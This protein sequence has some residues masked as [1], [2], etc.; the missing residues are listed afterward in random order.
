MTSKYARQFSL[1]EGFPQLLKDFTREVLRAQ[2]EDVYKFGFEYFTEA[3]KRRDN[4]DQYNDAS[5]KTRLSPE[6]LQERITALFTDADADGNGVLDRKE[7]KNVF[8][9][10]KE[11]LDL[12]QKDVM[13]I[14]AEA[15]ENDDGTIEYNEFVPIAVDVV[16]SIYAKQDFEAEQEGRK[17]EALEDARDFLLH[18]MPREELEAMLRD[19]FMKADRDGNGSLSRKEFATCIKEADLGFTRKEINVLLSE[20]DADND[21]KVTYEEFVPLCFTLLVEMVSESLVEAPQEEEELK[22]F[23]LQ[24]L[25]ASADAENKLHHTEIVN[26]LK[27]AD[28]GLTRVQIHAI[29]SEA[30]EDEQGRIDYEQLS[31]AMAGMVLCLVNV[32]MQQDRAEA[33]QGVRD[34]DGYGFVYGYDADGMYNALMGEFQKLDSGNQGVLPRDYVKESVTSAMPDISPKHC[35]AVMSLALPDDAGNVAY[36]DVAAEAY[37][38]LNWLAEQEQ[39]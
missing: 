38:V 28:L 2:T 11:E 12:D 37:A 31:N 25:G 24:L 19:V 18:G 26:L 4:P 10:L 21:G 17:E 27:D 36:G 5:A 33:L 9:G 20:V 32:Q 35:Q 34:S 6:E 23:F 13:K 39:M 7:F 8:N 22:E 16:N 1:P 29:M 15:D 14:M 3:I 30:E